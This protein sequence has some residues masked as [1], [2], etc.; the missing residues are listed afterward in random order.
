VHIRFSA[1]LATIELSERVYCYLLIMGRLVYDRCIMAIIK[2]TIIVNL[3]IVG[4]LRIANYS[5]R[6]SASG[7]PFLLCRMNNGVRFCQRNNCASD[8]LSPSPLR[9]RSRPSQPSTSTENRV[10][11]KVVDSVDLEVESTEILTHLR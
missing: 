3:S 11:R 5:S 9:P 2:D 10:D 4:Y 1:G 8:F 6:V 7:R